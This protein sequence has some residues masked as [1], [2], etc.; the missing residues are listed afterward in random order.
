MSSEPATDRQTPAPGATALHRGA[1]ELLRSSSLEMNVRDAGQLAQAATLLPTGTCVYVPW[2]PNQTMAQALEAVATIRRSGLDPVPHIAARRVGSRA[3][4]EGFLANAVRE[5]GVHRVMLIAGDATDVAGP[6]RDSIELI[7]DGVLA[8]SGLREIGLSG[9]PEGDPRF[10][11]AT[12]AAAFERKLALARAQA[13]GVYVVTQFSFA[14]ERIIEFCRTLSNR[15]PDVPL[16]I[17]IAGPTDPVALLRYAQ[18]C[19]VSASRRALQTL[20]IGIAKLVL[21][22][23]PGDQV[24]TVAQ[25]WDTHPSASVVGV[26]LY[27]F[28][29]FLATAKWIRQTIDAGLARR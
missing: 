15:H 26:H 16:Y 5:H 7:A 20:G 1:A 22:S 14:P 21:R 29:G 27:S 4:L 2:L 11:A 24:N 18:R 12:L 6:Y 25:Y 13:L 17:G 23:D 28:G 10:S 9:Y 8:E 19:G 3:E